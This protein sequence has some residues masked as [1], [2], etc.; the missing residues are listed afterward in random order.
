MCEIEL[1]RGLFA[2]ASAGNPLLFC[3]KYIVHAK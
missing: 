3:D 2:F 1:Y